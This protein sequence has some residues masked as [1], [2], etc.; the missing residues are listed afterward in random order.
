MSRILV[1]SCGHKKFSV[2]AHVTEEWIVD[3]HGE[4]LETGTDREV[5]H[6]P[7]IQSNDYL[8]SCAKCGEKA[9]RVKL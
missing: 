9:D 7:S 8:F 6:H 5:T 1:C 4:Y 3:E 2:M